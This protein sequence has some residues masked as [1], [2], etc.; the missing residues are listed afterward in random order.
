MLAGCLNLPFLYADQ[1]PYRLS[2]HITA[3]ASRRLHEAGINRLVH[4][5]TVE[6]GDDRDQTSLSSSLI[7]LLK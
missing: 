2:W 6:L 1:S 7:V 5:L 4:T 3:D